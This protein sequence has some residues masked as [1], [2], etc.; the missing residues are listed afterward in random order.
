LTQLQNPSSEGKKSSG[1]LRKAAIAAVIAG[2]AVVAIVIGFFA[3]NAFVS[4]AKRFLSYQEALLLHT[5]WEGVVKTAQR[6]NDFTHFSTDLTITASGGSSEVAPYLEGSSVGMSMDFDKNKFLLGADLTI[7]GSPIV[8]GVLTYDQG[9]MGFYVPELD[10]TYYT[11]DLAKLV[12]AETGIDWNSLKELEFPEIPLDVLRETGKTYLSV[13]LRMVNQKTVTLEKGNFQMEQVDRGE[14]KGEIYTFR[15]VAED[16]ENMLVELADVLEHDKNLHT[17]AEGFLGKNQ[18]VVNEFLEKS[19]YD[20]DILQ[21]LDNALRDAAEELRNHAEDAG[22]EVEESGFV[23]KLYGKGGKVCRME[24]S[25]EAKNTAVVFE[26]GDSGWAFWSEI[27][28]SPQ[29]SLVLRYEKENGF[30]TGELICTADNSE[31]VT[32]HFDKVDPGKQSALGYDYGIYQIS[33]PEEETLNFSVTESKNGG[34]DHAI[35]I[36]IPDSSHDLEIVIHTTDKK[37]V[38]SFPNAK[39]KDI[40]DYDEEDFEN[41]FSHWENAAQS[42][43]WNL[44]RVLSEKV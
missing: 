3:A 6:Y 27:D 41:L 18:A 43:M 29:G 26:Q 12:Q 31:N 19:G 42:L 21:E 22:K 15:P 17:L 38:I 10:D 35:A 32:L 14:K 30:Y 33:E 23:W 11:M 36:R 9:R 8:S 37:S 39:T 20:G 7:T 34:T 13:V 25:L 40:S 44:F 16:V 1:G 28:G 24:M 2:C 4:P 5:A